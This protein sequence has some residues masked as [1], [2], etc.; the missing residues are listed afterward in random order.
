M[1]DIQKINRVSDMIDQHLKEWLRCFSIPE[2]DSVASQ[3][4]ASLFLTYLCNFFFP[5]FYPCQIGEDDPDISYEDAFENR[6][7]RIKYVRSIFLSYGIKQPQHWSPL[8][9]IGYE[10]DDASINMGLLSLHEVITNIR[11]YL[12]PDQGFLKNL[13]NNIHKKCSLFEHMIIEM[14]SVTKEIDFYKS[15]L[16]KIH[17]I[18]ETTGQSQD[19]RSVLSILKSLDET[20]QT[21]GS[22]SRERSI[23]ELPK[24]PK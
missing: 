15:K 4:N 22:P 1:S 16:K 20:R 9:D 17:H 7:Q 5:D 10:N 23:T 3:A 24:K 18:A 12:T 19:T 8:V 13:S 14:D 21:T 6:K 2:I 11:F